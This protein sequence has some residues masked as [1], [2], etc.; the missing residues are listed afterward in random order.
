MLKR[1]FDIAVASV[2]LLALSPL[3][4]IVC[5]ALYISQGRPIFFRQT[6]VGRRGNQ[7]LLWKFRTMTSDASA[8]RGSFDLGSTKR[9]TAIGKI[10]RRTKIDELPQLLNVLLGQ[11]SLVGPRPEVPKW[12]ATY[13]E[14]WEKVL[15]VSPGITDPASI[16]YRNEEDLLRDSE[17]PEATYRE[18][19]L[20]H[21]LDLYEDYV[22]NRT[23]FG[24]LKIVVNTFIAVIFR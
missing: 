2:A 20:P 10:L 1:S 5:F 8:S 18:V 19:I 9:V 17:N 11:M 3:L 22:K 4:L 15:T 6:R 24:D 13:P 14:R 7:F 23:F 12:V 16:Q 21:K